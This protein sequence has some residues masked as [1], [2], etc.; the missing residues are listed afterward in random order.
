MF[1]MSGSNR[2]VVE[3]SIIIGPSLVVCCRQRG[4][5]LCAS[6]HCTWVQPIT[7]LRH[8]CTAVAVLIEIAQQGLAMNSQTGVEPAMLAGQHNSSACAGSPRSRVSKHSRP[9]HPYMQGDNERPHRL[10]MQ[11]QDLHQPFN[12]SLSLKLKAVYL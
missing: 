7:D 4:Y 10:L 2:C 3:L 9:D 8:I 11:L 5:H 1:S 6:R 12:T